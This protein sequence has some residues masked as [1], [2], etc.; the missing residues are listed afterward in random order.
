MNRLRASAGAAVLLWLLGGLCQP[1][2]AM[3]E[4]FTD[5]E[6][7]QFD[8]SDWLVERKGFLPIPIVITEP[9]VGY[10]GGV[11]FMFLRNSMAETAQKAKETGLN[12]PPDIWVFGAAATENG[13]KAAFA[14]G[15]VSFDE[16]RYKYRG[17]IGRANVN[18]AYYGI[19]G[20]G[21]GVNGSR[22][23]DYSLDGWVSSQQVLRRLGHTDNWFG[24]RWIYLD[25]SSK[26]DI[27]GKPNAKLQPNDATHK[28]SGLGVTLEHDSRD[29]IFT[30][31]SGWT[32]AVDAMFY[33]PD[34]GS[35]TTFQSYRG[36][37]F[38]YWPVGKSVVL[39]GRLDGRSARGQVPFYMLPFIDMRGIP[40]A[41]YQDQN[42]TVVETEVRWDF[43]P[44]WAAVGFIGAGRAWGRNSEFGDVGSAVS[45]GVGARYLIAR[46]LGIW[47]G[48]DF[49]RGP[50]GN[51]GYIQVGSAWR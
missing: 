45:K 33:D 41:R 15:M 18:L 21:G 4:G 29:N 6:D 40:A 37:V 28:A 47:V 11:A 44:R 26:L 12:I 38:S 7:G 35:A 50:E 14:G 16:G 17:G 49:A 2:W 8:M 25:L 1:A 13:T 19:G 43:T 46:K 10:G 9:A 51:A 20:S 3:L 34:W 48:L 23:I 36:H 27:S 24:L 30:P 42:T 31:S 32:G 5:A 22:G 39:A